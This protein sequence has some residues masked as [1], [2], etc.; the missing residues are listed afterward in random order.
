M[1]T[2]CQGGRPRFKGID[3]MAVVLR[4]E[5]RTGVTMPEGVVYRPIKI[6]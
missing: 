2:T 5:G 4:T 6:A 1:M 3:G